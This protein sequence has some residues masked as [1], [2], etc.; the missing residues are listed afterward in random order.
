VYDRLRPDW[1]SHPLLEWRFSLDI[2][3]HAAACIVALVVI[4]TFRLLHSAGLAR[5]ALPATLVM[6][7]GSELWTIGSQA[8]WQHGPAALM[9]VLALQL[10]MSER[11]PARLRTAAA[12]AC[13]AL[14]CAIR[15]VDLVF[16]A[17]I[18]LWV[19][20]FRTRSVGWLLLGM[21]PIVAL[22]LAH[23][24]YWFGTPLGGQTELDALHPQQHAITAAWSANPLPGMAGTLIS[25]SRGLLVFMP[26]VL[27]VV[28]VYPWSRGEMAAGSL[29]RWM[30][31][32][33]VPYL[34]AVSAYGVWWGGFCYGPR[35][36]TETSPI[37]ALMF[38]CAWQWAGRFKH[39][40]RVGLV[41]TAAW[42]VG[43]QALGA[44]CYPSS[45]NLTPQ[46]VDTHHDRLWDWS[47]SEV[48]R[49]IREKLLK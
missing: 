31:I 44:F 22:T 28:L 2:G 23:N 39:G 18:F 40:L 8:L 19:L 29:C 11:Q 21:A 32:S 33:L 36:W 37:L 30:V 38:G 13:A 10:L 46:N 49:C 12:G 14:M 25:P 17:A 24:V 26:W 15:L 4:C 9:L 47:D 43:L 27:V 1:R 41:I 16:A 20:R 34:S 5:A 35:Y 45:W 7:F 3:K 42:A 48:S 6:A